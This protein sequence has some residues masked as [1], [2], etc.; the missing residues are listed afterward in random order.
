MCVCVQ[1]NSPL[2]VSPANQEVSKP[3]PAQEGGA[4]RSANEAEEKRKVSGQGNSV[5]GRGSK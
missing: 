3:R 5:K 4:E 1:K 2:N